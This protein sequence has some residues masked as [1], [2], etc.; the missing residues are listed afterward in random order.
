MHKT[1]V[2]LALAVPLI[3]GSAGCTKRS[4]AWQQRSATITVSGTPGSR[5]TGH[6]EHRGNR[7]RFT[8][9]LPFTLSQTGLAEVVVRKLDPNSTVTVE[10]RCS[11][12]ETGPGFASI[13]APPGV[14]GV[15]VELRKGFWVG[16]LKE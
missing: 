3:L 15:H 7:H 13:A 9:G 6:Y 2:C 5:I 10:A 14:A 1:F 12:P 8:N 4:S 16:N 11:D